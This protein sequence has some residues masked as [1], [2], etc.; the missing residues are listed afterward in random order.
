MLGV[1]EREGELR[2]LEAGLSEDMYKR[3]KNKDRMIPMNGTVGNEFNEYREG[4]IGARTQ[5][6]AGE[7]RG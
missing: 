5:E 4:S 3:G 1:D 6:M 2:A 7:G